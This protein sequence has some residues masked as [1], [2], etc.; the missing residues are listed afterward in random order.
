M[1]ETLILNHAADM[2]G[3]KDPHNPGDKAEDKFRRG[4]RMARM[5]KDT[6]L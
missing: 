2:A 3:I 5:M 1:F 6:V 4:V